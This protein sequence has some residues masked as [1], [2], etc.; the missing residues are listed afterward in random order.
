MTRAIFGVAWAV[1]LGSGPVVTDD[2]PPK[3][4]TREQ[5]RQEADKAGKDPARLI[6]LAQQAPEEEARR[7]RLEA[8]GRAEE[9]IRSAQARAESLVA[10]AV[11]RR[12]LLEARIER[13][14]ERRESLLEEVGRLASELQEVASAEREEDLLSPGEVEEDEESVAAEPGEEDLVEDL[15]ES[16]ELDEPLAEELDLL[17]EQTEEFSVFGEEPTGEPTDDDER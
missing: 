7:L 10:D 5:L 2:L 4:L 15:E 9:S 13:L 3:S 11:Q 8:S 6:Q 14:L 16:T 1:F 12:R 17:D